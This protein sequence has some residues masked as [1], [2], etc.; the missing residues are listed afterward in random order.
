MEWLINHKEWGYDHQVLDSIDIGVSKI[1][2][3][4]RSS[5]KSWVFWAQTWLLW[6]QHAFGSNSMNVCCLC[7][8]GRA[9]RVSA[10]HPVRCSSLDWTS[11]ASMSPTVRP[12]RSFHRRCGYPL[13]IEHRNMIL[14]RWGSIA[15]LNYQRVNNSIDVFCITHITWKITMWLCGQMWSLYLLVRSCSI[16]MF[17]STL[18]FVFWPCS[19]C[20]WVIRQ[21]QDF[22]QLISPLVPCFPHDFWLN[23]T[24]AAWI[25]MWFSC[26]PGFIGQCMWCWLGDTCNIL[27]PVC[28]FCPS[29]IVN[30]LK[31]LHSRCQACM[32]LLVALLQARH[33]FKM[34]D[35]PNAKENSSK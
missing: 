4:S 23:A 35:W 30:K 28:C 29:C 8:A 15:M 11:T 25:L 12:P 13:G 20:F 5:S 9:G 3:N 26:M 31:P 6:L 32:L 7:W 22:R 14:K 17:L 27:Q 18:L 34:W 24:V 2:G 33:V 19:P 1:M 16:T 10:T 21:L